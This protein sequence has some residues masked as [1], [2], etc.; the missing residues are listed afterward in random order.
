MI[1]FLGESLHRKARYEPNILQKF[2]LLACSKG[3]ATVIAVVLGVFILVVI[4]VATLAHA[5]NDCGQ[6]ALT[7]DTGKPK[8]V[9]D[10]IATNGKQFPYKDIRLPRAVIPTKYKLFMHPNISNSIFVGTVKITCQVA[11][12]T[13]FIVFHIKDLNITTLTVTDVESGNQVPILEYLEYK[14]NE[15]VYVQLGTKLV[16]NKNVEINVG[17]KGDLVKKLAG[18][19]KSTYKTKSGEERYVNLLAL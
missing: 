10:Y 1:V 19:Y 5:S 7:K 9:Q 12:V 2:R 11:V 14:T 16:V 3:R 6:T 13:D 15:E 4:L 17:F 18:F 8:V